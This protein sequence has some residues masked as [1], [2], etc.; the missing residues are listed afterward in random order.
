MNKYKHKYKIMG[1]NGLIYVIGDAD[2]NSSRKR[3]ELYLLAVKNWTYIPTNSFTLI[4]KSE[5]K[6]ERSI[7]REIADEEYYDRYG[8]MGVMYC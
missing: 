2:T 5:I 7:A 4:L 1:T 3:I 6:D 8:M